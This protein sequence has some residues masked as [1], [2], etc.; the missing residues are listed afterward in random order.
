MMAYSNQQNQL[1]QPFQIGNNGLQTI[2]PRTGAGNFFLGEQEQFQNTPTQTPQAMSYLEQ[3]LSQSSEGLR[4]PYAGFDPIAQD[5]TRDFNT[6]TIPGIAER[7]TALGGGQRSSAFQGALGSAG[8][9]LAQKL[10]AMKAEY[11]LKNRD[12]LLRQ[13]QLGLTPQFETQ[14]KERGTGFLENL[15]SQLLGPGL[16]GAAGA[17][18]KSLGQFAGN[19]SFGNQAQQGQQGSSDLASLITKILPLLV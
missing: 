5:A 18:G 3:L 13:G 14:Y 10:A 9:G 7:F 11:G 8:S 4:N 2:K 16:S 1:F 17:Y 6:Q 15:L 19:K 12:S